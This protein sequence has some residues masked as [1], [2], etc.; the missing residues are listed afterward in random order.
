MLFAMSRICARPATIHNDLLQFLVSGL[1]GQFP[2]F[3]SCA[4]CN[5]IT[6]LPNVNKNKG[7]DD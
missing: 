7:V 3:W 6:K 5:I 1:S 4:M 2:H